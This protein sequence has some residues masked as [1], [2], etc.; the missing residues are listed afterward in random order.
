MLINLGEE[1]SEEESLFI[2]QKNAGEKNYIDFNDFK[3]IFKRS[4]VQN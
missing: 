1:M 3:R 2:F 4:S